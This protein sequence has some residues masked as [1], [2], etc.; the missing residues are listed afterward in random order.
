VTTLRYEHKIAK[1]NHRTVCDMTGVPIE[2][3]DR[4]VDSVT[5]DGWGIHHFKIHAVVE[6]IARFYVDTEKDDYWDPQFV[7]DYLLFWLREHIAEQVLNEAFQCW[8]DAPE[9]LACYE[10]ARQYWREARE[11]SKQ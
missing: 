8:T 4:F 6:D 7:C 10:A 3:G 5:A 2:K 9:V 11:A 1:R